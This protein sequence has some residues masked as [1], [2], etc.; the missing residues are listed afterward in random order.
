MP[1]KFRD[2]LYAQRYEFD[3]LNTKPLKLSSIHSGK[4]WNNKCLKY[5][6][7]KYVGKVAE[8]HSMVDN[9]N[10]PNCESIVLDAHQSLSKNI[11]KLL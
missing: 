8:R 1:L 10:N 6:T 2:D 5:I 11:Y 4:M 9:G 7:Q 3:Y